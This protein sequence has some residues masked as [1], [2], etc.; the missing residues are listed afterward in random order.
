MTP[1]T[2]EGTAPPAALRQQGELKAEQSDVV[3]KQR[4]TDVKHDFRATNIARLREGDG[5]D[6]VF[7]ALSLFGE[8]PELDPTN[9][10]DEEVKIAEIMKRPSRKHKIG[11]QQLH[12]D[13][14]SRWVP[15]R[16]ERSRA[17]TKREPAEEPSFRAARKTALEHVVPDGFEGIVQEVESFEELLGLPSKPVAALGLEGQLLFR[18][19]SST[20]SRKMFEV[21]YV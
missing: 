12:E 3:E 1:P 5:S 13:P 19:G 9:A 11:T 18:D 4:D 17:D 6:V 20:R 14:W 10:F 2:E 21:G 16:S 7:S 15:K 8:Y